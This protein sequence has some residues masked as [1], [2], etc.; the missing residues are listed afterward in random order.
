MKHLRLLVML[1]MLLLPVGCASHMN[2]MSV[3]PNMKLTGVVAKS[4]GGPGY[5]FAD[6]DKSYYDSKSFRRDV[7][8]HKPFETTQYVKIELFQHTPAKDYDFF[9]VFGPD[10]NVN[11][12][13][14]TRMNNS[15]PVLQVDSGWAYLDGDN[16]NAKTK[17]DWVSAGAQGTKIV[18]RVDNVTNTHYVYLLPSNAPNAAVNY[19]IS[20][21][22]GSGAFTNAGNTGWFI[23]IDSACNQTGP[24]PLDPAAIAW[25]AT[26]EPI[27]SEAE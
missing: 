4:A 24:M 7:L 23:S 11:E 26:V 15:D 17:S 2:A 10:P 21:N 20:C 22:N 6:F 5:A 13:G 27:Y 18:V 9:A 8:P 14:S 3:G 16:P 12:E 25:L 19:E 1:P